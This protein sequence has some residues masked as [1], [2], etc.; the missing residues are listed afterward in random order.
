MRT[1][2][3]SAAL[4]AVDHTTTSTVAAK[5]LHHSVSSG[6]HALARVVQSVGFAIHSVSNEAR[7]V[8]NSVLR[9]P[10]LYRVLQ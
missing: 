6:V 3:V 2:A 7:S 4:F 9:H 1:E 8:E 5:L 10:A